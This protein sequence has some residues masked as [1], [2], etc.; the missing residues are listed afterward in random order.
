M[1]SVGRAEE[2]F[3]KCDILKTRLLVEME[4]LA[5]GGL[6]AGCQVLEVIDH[7]R[8]GAQLRLSME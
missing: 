1:R 8:S 2:C 6:K 7:R 3:G 5:G 4:T